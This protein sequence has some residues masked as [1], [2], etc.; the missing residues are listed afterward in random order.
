MKAEINAPVFSP[1]IITLETKAELDAFCAIF[2][3]SS[4]MNAV[5][6]DDVPPPQ[7]IGLP[8]SLEAES[9][10]LKLTALLKTP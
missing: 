8:Y 6:L 3:H 9:L 10:H 2:N 5:G 7:D 1:V 4:I